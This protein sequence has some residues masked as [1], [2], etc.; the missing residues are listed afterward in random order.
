MDDHLECWLMDIA[1]ESLPA[2]N[3]VLTGRGHDVEAELAHQKSRKLVEHQTRTHRFQ[4]LRMPCEQERHF[5]LV[6]GPLGG[7]TRS[8]K[9][10]EAKSLALQYFAALLGSVF[11]M[12]DAFWNTE[13]DHPRENHK[14]KL[15]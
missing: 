7:D 9:L 8:S 14:G 2:V 5:R 15:G 4:C 11:A 12:H 6:T 1:S 10:S 13:K 3:Y